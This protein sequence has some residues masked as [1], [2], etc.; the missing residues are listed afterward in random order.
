MD[1]VNG[2]TR[3]SGLKVEE[4]KNFLRLRGLKVTGKKE[5]LVARVFVAVE[6][7]VPLLKTAEEVEQEIAK[8]YETKL[9]VQGKRIPDPLRHSGLWLNEEEGVKYW[10]NTL[11][12]DIFNFLAFHPSELASKDLSD[13]KTSK[14]YSY[15][16]QGW[17]SP[18]MINNLDKESKFCLLKGTCRPSQKINDTPHKLW[19]C[20]CKETGKILTTHC[21][22]MAGMSQTCNHV[23]AA[24]FRIESAC[25]M[26]LNNP[27]CTSK[28]CAWLPN[29]QPVKPM[30][31]SD[32]KL[33]RDN[34][35]KKRK[36]TAQLNSSKKRKFNPIAKSNYK[37]SITDIADAVKSVCKDSESCLLL[38][39]LPK[40][41]TDLS[42]STL[43][44]P[45]K[46]MSSI[47]LTSNSEKE[48][49]DK[50]L[51]YFTA[52]HICAV[53]K[54]TRGQSE[55]PDWMLFRK[56]VITASIA[57]DVMTRCSTLKRG[58]E[59][60]KEV[61]LTNVYKNIS[62]ENRLNPDL[63]ALKYGRCME[64]N[65]VDSF[66][67]SFKINHKQVCITECG[68]FLLAGLPYI[69]GSPDRIIECSCCGKACLEIKCPY[70][71]RH[72]APLDPSVHLSYMKK[73]DGKIFLNRKHKYFTQCQVQMASTGLS[74]CYFY[75]WTTHGSFLEKL[76]FL[77]TE[78][79]ET[80]NS[81]QNFYENHYLK[82][83][84]KQ[85]VNNNVE[86]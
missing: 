28:A 65:A 42:T 25:R 24:L 60:S 37:L 52:E 36:T 18:L 59:K 48:F 9:F 86:I 12:P 83:L 70:S 44:T 45:V 38:T 63:P 64:A 82:H 23:A 19:L 73:E 61:D 22:C 77:G 34:F 85:E 5:E 72:T 68:L 14:A 67:A 35:G 10:P 21:T 41:N 39:I 80:K 69:G 78:W 57:H 76:E 46:S 51:K 53:E 49:L 27:P 43:S 31:I 40:M 56:H 16:A 26:G 6:N 30:K 79:I 29:N 1:N 58:T 62:G 8:E 7:D 55:N 4:L 81:L 84:F 17:L 66:I 47:L 75:V 74:H 54:K 33:G 32:L 11:Y 2:L 50:S 15:F 20:L 3:I 13:Y 71:I